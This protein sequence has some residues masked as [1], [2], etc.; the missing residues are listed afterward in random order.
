M[1]HRRV[2]TKLIVSLILTRILSHT[3]AAAAAGS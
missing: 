3:T 1:A 2:R